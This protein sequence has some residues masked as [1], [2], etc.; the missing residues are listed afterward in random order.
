MANLC[1]ISDILM[2]GV[3]S[4]VNE[5]GWGFVSSLGKQLLMGCC[6]VLI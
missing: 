2:M 1:Y 6:T 5:H 3:G 4:C